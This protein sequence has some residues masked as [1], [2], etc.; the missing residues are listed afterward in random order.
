VFATE[1]ARAPAITLRGGDAL[2]EY[3]QAPAYDACLDRVTDAY[4]ERYS[5]GLSY[6]DAASWRH[7]LPSYAI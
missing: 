4:V 3:R 6:L 1:L 7:Y 5:A 2:D